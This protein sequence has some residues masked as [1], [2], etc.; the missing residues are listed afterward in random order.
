MSNR[1]FFFTKFK[2]V[3]ETIILNLSLKFELK[4]ATFDLDASS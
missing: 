2:P 3:I 1:L 4:V